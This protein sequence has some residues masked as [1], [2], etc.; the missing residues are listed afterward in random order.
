MAAIHT[1]IWSILVTLA[2]QT[3]TKLMFYSHIV[4]HR[5]RFAESETHL[6]Y[7]KAVLLATAPLHGSRF[8]ILPPVPGVHSFRVRRPP[9]RGRPLA[10]Q[11]EGRNEESKEGCKHEAKC[12]VLGKGSR[13]N[14]ARRLN[15]CNLN[16]NLNGIAS[17]LH[18]PLVPTRQLASQR[19]SDKTGAEC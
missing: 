15:V 16:L 13:F 10:S 4:N 12:D 2:T 5:A 17:H 6:Q 3:V 11:T 8:V 9:L 7:V 19:A 18:S 14:T 1:Y